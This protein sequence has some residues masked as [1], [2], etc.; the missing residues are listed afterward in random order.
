LSDIVER[1]I[2]YSVRINVYHHDNVSEA[3]LYKRLDAEMERAI[4]GI[5][6][7]N[8]AEIRLGSSYKITPDF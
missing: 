2:H 6:G 8:S 3:E 7:I 4:N 1:S 5:E